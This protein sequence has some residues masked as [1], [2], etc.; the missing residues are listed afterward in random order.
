MP[1]PGIEPGSSPPQGDIL[2]TV[3]YQQNRAC[4]ELNPGLLSDSQ[5]FSPTILQAR[6]IPHYP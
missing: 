3:L 5:V 6:H 2:T 4:R 1:E